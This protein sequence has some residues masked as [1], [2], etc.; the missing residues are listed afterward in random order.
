MKKINHL[1]Y[2]RNHITIYCE[3]HKMT[4]F[5][6]EPFVN[7][8]CSC[9]EMF[10]GHL[11]GKGIECLYEDS[12]FDPAETPVVHVDD[13]WEF[14]KKRHAVFQKEHNPRLVIKPKK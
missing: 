12:L 6:D 13:P 10:N 9:C 3:K 1:N 7:S 5:A 4:V 11:Q 8:Y 2:Y 14:E